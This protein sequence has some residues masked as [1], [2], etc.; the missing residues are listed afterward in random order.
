MIVILFLFL[1]NFRTTAISVVSI[2]LSL[3]VALMLAGGISPRGAKSIV[4]RPPATEEA[5]EALILPVRS[6][7]VPLEDVVLN[8]GERIEV[9]PR[10]Q[11]FVTIMG[12]VGGP[13]R[14][15]YDWTS[16][17]NL[18]EA[19]TAAGGVRE[20]DDSRY[21][22]IYRRDAAQRLLQ[23]R[24][25]LNRNAGLHGVSLLHDSALGDGAFTAIKAGD[26][27]VVERTVRSRTRSFITRTVSLGASAG[28]S[29]SVSYHRDLKAS[30]A[31]R[32]EPRVY[33]TPG[34]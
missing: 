13:G 24:F 27:L 30:G 32:G 31:D 4:I 14:Y 25:R 9:R 7:S 1:W 3:A 22:S 10:A 12:L 33:V 26:V 15:P 11:E 5:G 34:Q 16:P 23:A 21:V 29:T 2:P 17:P 28:A 8:G 20:L 6:T 19:L 18:I